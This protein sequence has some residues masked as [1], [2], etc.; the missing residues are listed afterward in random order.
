MDYWQEFIKTG[1]VS[2]YLSYKLSETQKQEKRK[3]EEQDDNL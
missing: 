2:D 3:K 1:L